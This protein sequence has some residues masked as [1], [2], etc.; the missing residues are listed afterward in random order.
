MKMLVVLLFLAL[1]SSQ[2]IAQQTLFKDSIGIAST[3]IVMP[4]GRVLLISRDNFLG[5][6]KFLHNEERPD[7]TYSKYEFF[8]YRKGEFSKERGGEVSLKRPSDGKGIYFHQSPDDLLGPPLKLGEFELSASAGSDHATV[9]FWR[10]P[11]KPDL[12]V[13]MAP[14]IWKDISEVNISDSRIKWFVHDDK[15]TWKVI[16]IEKVWE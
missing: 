12:R 2:V 1:M 11:N 15:E 6:I 16:P 7:G 13:R 3:C 5:A 4:V 9:Y 10:A 8:E 14:T